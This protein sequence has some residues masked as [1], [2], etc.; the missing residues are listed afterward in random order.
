MLNA[1][2]IVHLTPFSLLATGTFIDFAIVDV[3]ICLL[4]H[5]KTA[6]NM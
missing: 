1:I 4:K 6:S 5:I 3:Q 2:F